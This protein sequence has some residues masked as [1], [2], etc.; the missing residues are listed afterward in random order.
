MECSNKVKQFKNW[1]C[2]HNIKL[3]CCILAEIALLKYCNWKINM[4][5]PSDLIDSIFN[6]LIEKYKNNNLVIDKINKYKDIS[7]TLLEFSICEYSIFSKYN[8]I[9]IAL[10]SCY[11]SINQD[12][13][14]ENNEY[15]N[16]L[17]I[18]NEL[19]DI[20]DKFVNN[21]KIDKNLIED[22]SSFILNN[23]EKDDENNDKEENE[24]KEKKEN[25]LDFSSQLDLTR[26]DSDE[27]FCEVI[28]NYFVDK[29]F[30][31]NII[32]DD[33]NNLINFWKMSPIL[34]KELISLNEE[35]DD[36]LE[37]IKDK[38]IKDKIVSKTV[39]NEKEDLILLNRK[40]I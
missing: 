30:D 36:N 21:L 12:I 3:T 39:L 34:H 17:S 31:S 7:I 8:Q 24:M 5:S 37:C 29:N 15:V 32:S 14:E 16:N 40:R 10:S 18:Q 26:T 20:L 4:N 11:I 35:N 28:N 27:S 9:I 13:E 1:A 6:N 22:C 19:R 38:K 2:S 25:I 23:L 33:D